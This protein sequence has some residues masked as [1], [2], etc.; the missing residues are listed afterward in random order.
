MRL[1]F[2]AKTHNMF[3]FSIARLL[4]LAF[5]CDKTSFIAQL[6]CIVLHQLFQINVQ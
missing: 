2:N 6:G 5:T 1:S 3:P 4:I